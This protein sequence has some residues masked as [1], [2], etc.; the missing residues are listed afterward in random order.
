MKSKAT[1]VGTAYFADA[2]VYV[3]KRKDNTLTIGQIGK[4]GVNVEAG[5]VDFSSESVLTER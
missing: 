3:A 5:I 4:K 2:G 1:F